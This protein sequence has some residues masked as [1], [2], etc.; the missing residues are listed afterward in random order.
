MGG[1]VGYKAERWYANTTFSA[2]GSTQ[3]GVEDIKR[4]NADLNYKYDLQRRWYTSASISILSNSEQ[5]LD[6]R[7]NSKIGMGNYLA[8][9]NSMFLGVKLGVNRNV[10]RYTNDDDDRDSWEGYFGN[11]LSLFDIGDLKL[12][13]LAL[14]YPSF[15]ESQRWRLETKLD[16]KYD[17]PLDFFINLNIILNFDNQTPRDVSEFD[18]IIKTGFGWE[19]N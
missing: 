7:W 19:L 16:L 11:E 8:R 18:Y 9:T 1:G 10:E 6:M 4:F 15:T 2:L 12:Y 5:M 13:V 17:L 14:A 3:E